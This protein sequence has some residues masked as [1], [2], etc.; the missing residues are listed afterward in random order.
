MDVMS[1]RRRLLMQIMGGGDV[2]Q[3]ISGSF[4]GDGTATVE[5]DIGFEPDVIIIDS[6]IDYSTPGTKGLLMVAIAK[7]KSR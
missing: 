3:S 2:A 5:L 6:G 4:T 7:G 1:I